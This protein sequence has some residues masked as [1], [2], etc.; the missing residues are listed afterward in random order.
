MISG[1]TLAIL[2]VLTGFLSPLI[3]LLVALF[4]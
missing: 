2:G 3:G 1:D 4:V